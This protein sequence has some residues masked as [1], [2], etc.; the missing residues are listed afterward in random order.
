MGIAEEL[1]RRRAA[2]AEHWDGI[3]L[4]GAGRPIGIPGRAD[5]TYPFRAHSEYLYLTDRNR[6][7][8]VLA[9][10]P[11][12]GWAD[13]VEP[14]TAEERLWS[15]ADPGDVD[16]LPLARLGDWLASRAG[17]PLTWLGSPPPAAANVGDP[18][19]PRAALNAIR[20]VKDA[21]ELERMRIATAASAAGYETLTA[22]IEPGRSER[23]LQIE[24]EH[25]FL[26][27][28]ADAP[29][30]DTIVASGPNAAVLHF[31]P[32]ARTLRA[33][34]LLLVDAGAEHRAYAS[35][36]TRTYPATGTLDPVQAELHA[37]VHAAQQAAIA[38]CTPGTEWTDVHEAAARSVAEGLTGFGLLRGRDPDGLIEQ[39]AVT[40]FFPHGI[41]HMVGLGVRDAGERLP[42]RT[43]RPGFP[44]LRVDLPLE[45][46][47]T[48]TV[49]PGVYFV[50]ALLADPD[51]RR[52]LRDAVD[53]D[54][55]DALTGFGGIRLE[56]NV[57]VTD[58]EPEVLTAAIP[59]LAA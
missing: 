43:P 17:A 46:G 55:A 1:E 57:L 20:R 5:L 39:G 11:G 14:V 36:V 25:A 32:T 42:G 49:E 4:V 27:A 29:A 15:G 23:G 35:D 16:G 6:P 22:L 13:F 30:F 28:G 52:R 47:H 58:G 21:V 7:G 24:L 19:P 2:V 40:L 45:A 9:Y 33:G 50:P 53:W 41:G 18:A 31:A 12:A 59:L 48:V 38:R 10:D 37:V 34:E 51:T 54:R 44:S 8:G 56:E 3:V 26:L